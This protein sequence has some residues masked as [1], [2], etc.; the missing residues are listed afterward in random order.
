MYKVRY[1]AD[2]KQAVGQFSVA[3]C[4]SCSAVSAMQEEQAALQ[5]YG[6][7]EKTALQPVFPAVQF[8]GP[9]DLEMLP[10]VRVY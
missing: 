4:F 1:K 5:F 6:I 8:Y 10:Q 9:P 7:T 2:L 3:A